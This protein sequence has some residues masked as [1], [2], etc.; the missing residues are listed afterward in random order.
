MYLYIQVHS[1]VVS[2]LSV[3]TVLGTEPLSSDSDFT[4]DPMFLCIL[5]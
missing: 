4:C 2:D 3:P 5:P 1:S